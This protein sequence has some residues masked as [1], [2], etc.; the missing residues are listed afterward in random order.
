MSRGKPYW[1]LRADGT[2]KSMR[3]M[4]RAEQ[5]RMMS[6][7]VDRLAVEFKRFGIDVTYEIEPPQKVLKAKR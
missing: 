7:S 5:D 3:E 4:T 1:P 6:E 2:Q